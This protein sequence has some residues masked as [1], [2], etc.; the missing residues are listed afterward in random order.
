MKRLKFEHAA[1][2]RKIT[3]ELAPKHDENDG[4]ENKPEQP[5]QTPAETKSVTVNSSSHKSSMVAAPV[6]EY[7][8]REPLS[9]KI[10][11]GGCGV[12]PLGGFQVKLKL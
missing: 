2:D 9:S 10:V 6:S 5:H 4:T 8:T 11:I 7:K 3:A 1:L 12:T